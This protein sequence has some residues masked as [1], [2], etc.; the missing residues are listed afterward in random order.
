MLFHFIY[1]I[2]W[3]QN[4]YVGK[5]NGAKENTQNTTFT[6]KEPFVQVPFIIDAQQ[7]HLFA[8]GHMISL[9]LEMYM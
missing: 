6:K 8:V 7:L 4:N 3:L 2:L 1:S 5:R 9:Y